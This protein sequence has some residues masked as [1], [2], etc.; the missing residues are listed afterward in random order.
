MQKF[1]EEFN[2]QMRD[3]RFE[4]EDLEGL[5]KKRDNTIKAR[6]KRIEGMEEAAKD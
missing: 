6:D 1:L 4:K 2:K 5:V 3:L